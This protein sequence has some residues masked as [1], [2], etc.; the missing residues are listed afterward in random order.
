M[1]GPRSRAHLEAIQVSGFFHASCP[2]SPPRRCSSHAAAD[3]FILLGW[4][5]G[6]Y[7]VCLSSNPDFTTKPAWDPLVGVLATL[8]DM[9]LD[10]STRSKAS[11][12][13]GALTR[14]RRALRSVCVVDSFVDQ[15]RI[16][17]G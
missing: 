5:C 1:V 11:I 6:I 10:K 17:H 8:I 14:V 12:Q 15:T 13:K 16:E 7:D 9:L 2:F 3:M 4:S